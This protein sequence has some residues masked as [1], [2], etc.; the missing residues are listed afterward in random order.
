MNDLEKWREY[1]EENKE[2]LRKSGVRML[3]YFSRRRSTQ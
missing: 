2:M 1:C 3:A